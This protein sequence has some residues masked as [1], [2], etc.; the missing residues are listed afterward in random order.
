MFVENRYISQGHL[1]RQGRQAVSARRSLLRRGRDQDVRRRALPPARARLRGAA[2][3]GRHLA[4]L[5]DL[6]RRHGALLH[7][8]RESCTRSTAR[9]A[10]IPP[11]RPRARPIPIRRSRTSR[12]SSSSTTIWRSAGFRPFHS[13]CG[14]MLNEENMPFSTCI[15]CMDCDGF[16][17]LV[18]AKSDAEVIAVRPALQFPNVTLLTNARAMRLKTNADRHRGHRGEVEHDGAT[19]SYRGESWWSPAAP[20]TR[21]ACCSRPRSDKHPRGLANGSDQ[22]G[23]NYMCHNNQ[24]G[25]GGLEGAEPDPLPEDAGPERL[26]LQADPT[27]TSRSATPDGRQVAGADVPGREAHRQAGAAVDAGDAGQARA[28]TS[29]C[30]PRTCRGPRTASPWSATAASVSA[31]RRPTRSRPSSSASSSSRC[32]ATSGCTRITWSRAT[33]T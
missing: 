11:S 17:C 14:I 3:P 13:P 33:S 18:H 4:G 5:A 12:A 1:V 25:D 30:A 26:L 8:R 20:R 15:R 6:V 27:P 22:V 28:S 7:A 21:P 16:P 24:V 31:T 23:R 32:W 9:A 19:E 2:A 10:R 29:G